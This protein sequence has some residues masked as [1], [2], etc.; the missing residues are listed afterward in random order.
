M[1]LNTIPTL[2]L[3]ALTTAPLTTAIPLNTRQPSSSNPTCTHIQPTPSPPRLD[4][5]NRPD[6]STITTQTLTFNLP[7]SSST[8]PCTLRAH[9]P[10]HWEVYDSRVEAGGAPLVVNVFDVDGSGSGGSGGSGALVGSVQFADADADANAAAERDRIVTV[11]SLA[12]RESMSFRFELASD[13]I[14]EVG[15]VQGYDAGLGVEGGLEVVF[16]ESC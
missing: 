9:F 8:G 10:P 13:S 2:L 12:C 4:L 11:G 5:I 7:S 15:F 16:G 1:H 3:A 14:G 6:L